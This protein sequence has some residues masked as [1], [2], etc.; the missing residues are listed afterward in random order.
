MRMDRA[1]CLVLRTLCLGICAAGLSAFGEI[2][3]GA[4]FAHNM[5]L[6]RGMRVPV[7]G[8]AAAGE[9]VRGLSS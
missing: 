5:V 3:P 9:K 4:P 2:V 8:V 7:C 6:Q 1:V